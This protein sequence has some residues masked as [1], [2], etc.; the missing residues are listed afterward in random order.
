MIE[1]RVQ[2]GAAAAASLTTV[3]LI[4]TRFPGER[5][6]TIVIPGFDFSGMKPEERRLTLGPEWKYDA[7]PACVSALSEFGEVTVQ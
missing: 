1:L 6:L 3:K 2:P 7:S 5:R 4:A